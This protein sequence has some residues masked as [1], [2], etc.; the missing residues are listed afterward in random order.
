MCLHTRKGCELLAYNFRLQRVSEASVH[1]SAR[2]KFKVHRRHFV[3]PLYSIYFSPDCNQN[4]VGVL[5]TDSEV[6]S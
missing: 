4:S 2:S 5:F 1:N 3:R 6:C